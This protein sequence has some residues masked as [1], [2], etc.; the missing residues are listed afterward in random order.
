MAPNVILIVCDTMR[1]DAVSVYNKSARTPFLTKF[2]RDAVV[3]HDAI[4]PS[5]WTF[6][7]HVSMFTG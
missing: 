7:S 1:K 3:Y 2:A 6:P 5:S 4:A